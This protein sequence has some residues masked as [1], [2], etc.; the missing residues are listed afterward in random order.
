MKTKSKDFYMSQRR[1]LKY[2]ASWERN[3]SVSS[4]FLVLI[5]YGQ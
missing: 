3:L 5:V 2:K 1:K 4:A